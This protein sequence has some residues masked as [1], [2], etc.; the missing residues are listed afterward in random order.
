MFT[1]KYRWNNQQNCKYRHKR[2][3]GRES[4][5][6]REIE[7]KERERCKLIL[8]LKGHPKIFIQ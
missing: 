1:V 2:E 4:E 5:R 8:Q 3:R 6:E 7:R